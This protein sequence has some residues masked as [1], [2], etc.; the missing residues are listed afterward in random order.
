MAVQ[1]RQPVPALDLPLVG[2]GRYRLGDPKPENFSVL[3]FYRG[4]HCRRCPGQ[5]QSYQALLPNFREIGVEVIAISSDDADRAGKSAAQWG[6]TTLP[7]AFGFPIDAA[8]DWE[9]HVSAGRKPEDPPVFTE[10]AT[11]VVDRDGR[12][13]SG[14]INTGPRLRP[15]AAD[16]LAHVR[17][18][19]SETASADA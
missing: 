7:I 6:I 16:L 8:P 4:L 12:L 11:F 9:L 18:R 2:G 19:I 15:T 14:V 13:D 3:V 1:T 17:D 5:L 10:P